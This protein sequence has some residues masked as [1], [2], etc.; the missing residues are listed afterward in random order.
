MPTKLLFILFALNVS[1]NADV[2]NRYDVRVD[3]TAFA[4][5]GGSLQF[6]L[7]ASGVPP[8]VTAA[9]DNI[10][11][12][13][14]S[15]N[16]GPTINL[17]NAALF[18]IAEV[19]VIY[20]ALLDFHLTLDAAP[21]SFPLSNSTTFDLGLLNASGNYLVNTTA[22]GGPV[23]EI[24]LTQNGTFAATPFNSS[25]R[26]ANLPEPLSVALTGSGLFALALLRKR[27]N[28]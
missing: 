6:V 26:V 16:A 14:G 10:V 7:S 27:C 17:T 9:I 25:I 3:T 15:P 1:L 4:G 5:T 18:D 23:L 20:G 19:P 2:V 8:G 11:M 28:R 21:F 13:G 22:G 24:D 12:L